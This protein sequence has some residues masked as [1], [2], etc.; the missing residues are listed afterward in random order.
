MVGASSSPLV[1]ASSANVN[2]KVMI[3]TQVVVYRNSAGIIFSEG[4]ASGNSAK[5]SVKVMLKHYFQAYSSQ[6]AAL[7]PPGSN[8]SGMQVP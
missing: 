6:F 2:R 5:Q 3:Y 4:K 8:I 1:L 7:S